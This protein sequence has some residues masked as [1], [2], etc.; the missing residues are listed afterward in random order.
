MDIEIF[1][2]CKTTVKHVTENNKSIV[3][4]ENDKTKNAVFYRGSSID[5][6]KKMFSDLV[7]S[8]QNKIFD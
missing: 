2:D 8:V 5:R 4:V 6:A 1:T 3:K 7:K